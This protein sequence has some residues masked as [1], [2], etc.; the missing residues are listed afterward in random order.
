MPGG[1]RACSRKVYERTLAPQG[2]AKKLGALINPTF[3]QT[4]DMRSTV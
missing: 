3:E 2:A 4:A 1:L